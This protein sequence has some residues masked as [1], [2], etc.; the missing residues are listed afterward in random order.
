[1]TIN[2][3][4]VRVAIGE[5]QGGRPVG[6]RVARASPVDEA[7]G[8]S[9]QRTEPLFPPSVSGHIVHLNPELLDQVLARIK[10]SPLAAT[11]RQRIEAIDA[12]TWATRIRAAIVLLSGEAIDAFEPVPSKPDETTTSPE[13]A[14]LLPVRLELIVAQKNWITSSAFSAR[15][16]TGEAWKTFV[17]RGSWLTGNR[18]YL[19]R[20]DLVVV[21]LIRSVDRQE[22]DAAAI[23]ARGRGSRR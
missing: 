17:D 14:P 16:T 22:V 21:G 23:L 8:S 12:H 4:G 6:V 10:T 20:R 7:A 5:H 18:S 15:S 13:L 1:M 2:R 19:V 11:V 9:P 3:E